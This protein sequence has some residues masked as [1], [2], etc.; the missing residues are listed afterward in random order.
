[1]QLSNTKGKVLISKCCKS[2]EDSSFSLMWFG[3][4]KEKEKKL[5]CLL[6]TSLISVAAIAVQR[7]SSQVWGTAVWISFQ[8]E[9]QQSLKSEPK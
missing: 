1:M 6:I 5:L 4:K 2:E 3:F 9:S 8:S 7:H